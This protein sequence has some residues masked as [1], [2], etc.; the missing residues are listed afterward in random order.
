MHT[1]LPSL[2]ANRPL[3]HA[4][5]LVPPELAVASPNAHAMHAVLPLLPWNFPGL[6][7][8]HAEAPSTASAYHPAVHVLH[9]DWALAANFPDAHSSHSDRP[10]LR[11]NSPAGQLWHAV[12]PRSPAK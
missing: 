2:A 8:R 9:A 10:A 12:S 4:V 7:L 6:H 5:H 1:E 3:A 11:A